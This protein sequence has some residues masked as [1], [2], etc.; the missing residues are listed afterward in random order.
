MLGTETLYKI[1]TKYGRVQVKIFDE[2]TIVDGRVKIFVPNER[3]VYFDADEQRLRL[4][5]DKWIQN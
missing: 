4:G 2:A 5:E 3:L 1:D